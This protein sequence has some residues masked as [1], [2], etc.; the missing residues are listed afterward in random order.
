MAILK[1]T[2]IDD[3]GF[4]KLPSGTTTER[5]S[6]PEEGMI[7]FNQTF[8][9]I[10]Y[11]DGNKWIVNPEVFYDDFEI[12]EGWFTVGAGSVVQSSIQAFSGQFS[13]R[14]INNDDPNGAYKILNKSVSRNYELECQIF[15]EVPI[16]SGTGIRISVVDELGNGYGFVTNETTFA[17]EIRDAY[18]GTTIGTSGSFTRP[19]NQWHRMVFTANNNNT[20]TLK[21]FNDSNSLL[22]ELTSP[23]NSTHTG[24]FDR[25]AIL[26]GHIYYVDKLKINFI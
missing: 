26:G 2:I 20:F 6:S 8:N 17:V 12:F 11:Y 5:P 22:G 3:S 19:A 14:K 4:L 7:R 24:N 9:G 21:I 13:A 25:V 18:I 23:A 10:E 1:N 15:S 16:V